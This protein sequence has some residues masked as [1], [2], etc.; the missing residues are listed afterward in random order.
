[1]STDNTRRETE[2]QCEQSPLLSRILQQ[3]SS[4]GQ[5]IPAI[6]TFLFLAN[7]SAWA[8]AVLVFRISRCCSALHYSPRSLACGTRSMPTISPLKHNFTGLG[9][10]TIGLFVAACAGSVFVYR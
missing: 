8:W 9:V 3:P 5:S 1:V 4:F 7:L 10:A 2:R 6:Y